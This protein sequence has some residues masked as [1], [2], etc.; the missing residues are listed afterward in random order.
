T[1]AFEPAEPG[2]MKRPPRPRDESLLAGFVV[3]RVIFVSLLFLI[4]IFAAWYWA[5]HQFNDESV[6]RTLAVN[7]LVAME[8]FYLFAVR[9]LDSASIT[10]RGVLGTPVV[11][12]AVAAVILLQWLFTYLPFFHKTF[13]TAPLTPAALVF[14]VSAGVIVL[15]VL[16]LETW[17][18][19]RFYT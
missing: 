10:L 11:L 15:V 3:W 17:L 12:L 18:R 14:A 13:E 9:Y 6:A 1:L 4:G 16:E 8:V 19:R 5:M 2:V 7:T